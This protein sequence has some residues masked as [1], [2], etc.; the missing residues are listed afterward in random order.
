MFVLAK[1]VAAESMLL[2]DAGEV[3]G[4]NALLADAQ[5]FM[6]HLGEGDSGQVVGI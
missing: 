1:A 2:G 5:V 6:K 4:L 3:A